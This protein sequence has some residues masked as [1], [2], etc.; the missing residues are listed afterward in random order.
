MKYTVHFR[1][2]MTTFVALFGIGCST[3]NEPA[4]PT[5]ELYTE[6]EASSAI[7][8]VHSGTVQVD[9]GDL[10]DSLRIDSVRVLFSRMIL[11]RSKDDSTQGPR[12]T[13]AGPMVLTWSKAGMRRD[14]SADIE[15]GLYKR[16]KLEM[17][18]F[19]GSEAT[20]YA[21]H[22]VY[23]DFATDKRSC[24]IVD[25]VAFIGGKAEPFRVSSG[26]SGNIFMTFEPPIQVTESGTQGIVLSMDMV[27]KFKVTGGIRNPKL[28]KTLDAIEEI[29]ESGLS[30]RKR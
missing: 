15:A 13:K 24:M 5:F 20:T 9:D 7:P 3:S 23:G 14:L 4:A 16:L 10:V 11:H 26:K 22:P 27:S 17:H 25:G 21:G 18:K 28:P 1:L 30:F 19:S 6:L 29:L 8:M 2:M 12:N